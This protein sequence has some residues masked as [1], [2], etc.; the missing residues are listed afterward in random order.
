MLVNN[1]ARCYIALATEHS[2]TD[3]KIIY[4]YSPKSEK[5]K[6]FYSKGYKS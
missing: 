2:M 5:A 4:A 1:I 6:V 3:L